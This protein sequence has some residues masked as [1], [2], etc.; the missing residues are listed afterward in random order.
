MDSAS[1]KGFES[2]NG[3]EVEEIRELKYRGVRRR[4]W[5]KWVSEIREPKKKRRIWL[6]SYDSPQMAARA[7]DAAALCLKGRSAILNFPHAANSL[8]RPSS[9]HSRDIQAAASRAARAFDPHKIL[10]FS[11]HSSDTQIQSSSTPGEEEISRGE[12]SESSIVE[13][14]GEA[15]RMQSLGEVDPMED[16]LVQ[17]PNMWTNM[18]EALILT[19][20]RPKDEFEDTDL[21]DP[22]YSL[23]SE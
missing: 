19:P 4:S 14:N 13:S 12:C 9:S 10:L 1:D 15:S 22:L 17:S 5:G 7:Y 6:G 8:P 20:P 2:S 16:F 23:W 21:V 3:R 11:P 18:A